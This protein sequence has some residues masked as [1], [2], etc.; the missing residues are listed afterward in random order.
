MERSLR[1]SENKSF[2]MPDL[3]LDVVQKIIKSCKHAINC[4]NDLHDELAQI[5]L[6]DNISTQINVLK[7]KFNKYV[8]MGC[9]CSFEKS[10]ED[11]IHVLSQIEMCYKVLLGKERYNVGDLFYME[12]TLTRAR[13]FFE[14]KLDELNSLYQP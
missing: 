13:E 14:Y 12:N 5:D 2:E 4:L 8:I 6:S 1:V 9:D 11:L 3:D 7:P 10:D